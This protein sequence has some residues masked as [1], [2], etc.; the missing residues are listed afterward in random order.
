MNRLLRPLLSAAC[1][2]FATTALASGSSAP[3]NYTP[4][5]AL[6]TESKSDLEGRVR[7]ACTAT[8]A[9]IQNASETRLER[10]CGC[11]ATRVMRGL[12]DS[13]LDAYRNTGVFNEAARAKALAA[14]DS[15]KLKRPL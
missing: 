14:I 7:R 11:Y 9:K 1:L 12:D 6:K 10:P 15:C 2:A 3:F 5:P 8:Q 4:D 13:E